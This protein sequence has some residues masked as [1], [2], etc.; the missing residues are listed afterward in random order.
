[1]MAKLDLKPEQDGLGYFYGSYV[2]GDGT[3]HRVDILP[4]KSEPCPD[5]VMSTEHMHETDWIILVDG[6]EIGRVRKRDEADRMIEERL[7]T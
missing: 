1:M 6:E 3:R 2:A 5:F 4:P 7:L